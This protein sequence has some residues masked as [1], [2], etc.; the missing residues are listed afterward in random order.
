MGKNNKRIT[1]YVYS[2]SSSHTDAVYVNFSSNPNLDFVLSI[3]KRLYNGGYRNGASE[4][5]AHPDATINLL[6]YVYEGEDKYEVERE[7]LVKLYEARRT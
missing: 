3:A 2:L 5:L 6:R 7:A 4:I 1:F